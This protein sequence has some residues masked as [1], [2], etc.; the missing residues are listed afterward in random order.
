M[1]ESSHN[2][3]RTELE[4]SRR[5]A[6]RLLKRVMMHFRSEMDEKLQ[7]FGVTKA[8]IQLLWA[9]R[10]APGSSGAH[11]SRLCEVTPQTMQG[12]IQKTE[13]SGWI[14][15]GKD[16]VNERIVTA[17]LTPAGERLLVTAESVVKTIEAQ[18]WD[19]I[20][21]QALEALSGVLEKCLENISDD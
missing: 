18:L 10:N 15:R 19:G 3:N 17:S 13:E 8:Q 9:I 12:L 5:R 7:P 16:R 11:L 6:A 14:V 21:A 4:A 20:P 2:A 1:C